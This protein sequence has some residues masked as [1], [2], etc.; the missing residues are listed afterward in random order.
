MA[1]LERAE[2]RIKELEDALHAIRIVEPYSGTARLEINDWADALNKTRRIA[3]AVL[4]DDWE[5]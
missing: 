1:D 5:G 4:D 3:V 2:A